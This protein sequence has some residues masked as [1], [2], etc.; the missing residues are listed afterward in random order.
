V[1]AAAIALFGLLV[2]LIGFF[3][4]VAWGLADQAGEELRRKRARRDP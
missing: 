3:V 2:C 1:S 4:L